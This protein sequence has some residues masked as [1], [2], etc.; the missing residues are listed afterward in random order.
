MLDGKLLFIEFSGKRS[1]QARI[2][3]DVFYIKK[4]TFQGLIRVE[5]DF[6][7]LKNSKDIRGK[8]APDFA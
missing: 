7:E 2:Y 5:W 1:F 4:K 6:R 8:H 3:T